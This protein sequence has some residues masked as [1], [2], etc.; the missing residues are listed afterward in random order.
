MVSRGCLIGLN[1]YNAFL[2]TDGQPAALD[3]LWRH[4]EHFLKLGAEHCLALGSDADG[5][6]LP[7]CLDDPK[8]FAGLYRFFLDRGLSIPQVEGI[9]WKNAMNFF[10][11][12]LI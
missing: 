12:Q 9:L 8:K 1:Y 7:P 4:V 5:A 10:R 3:D 6:D 11:G 2:R